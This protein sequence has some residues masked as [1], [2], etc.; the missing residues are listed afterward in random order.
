M[1]VPETAG[2]HGY[3]PEMTPHK[4]RITTKQQIVVM[5]HEIIRQRDAALAE[6]RAVLEKALDVGLFYKTPLEERARRA[7]E[8]K[9]APSDGTL[10]GPA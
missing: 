8:G 10:P 7:L 9:E 3:W 4:I 6:L 2:E 1:T 5:A